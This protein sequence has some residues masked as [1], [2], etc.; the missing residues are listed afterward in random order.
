MRLLLLRRVKLMKLLSIDRSSM[1]VVLGATLRMGFKGK[2]SLLIGWCCP[3]CCWLLIVEDV[4]GNK[5]RVG[6]RLGFITFPADLKE[7]MHHPPF[8]SIPRSPR[9]I[10]AVVGSYRTAKRVGKTITSSDHNNAIIRLCPFAPLERVYH[11]MI[12]LVL[13]TARYQWF[14]YQHCHVL[15]GSP[16][17]TPA[18]ARST[19]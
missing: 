19:I 5:R 15:V 13:T 16:Q 6:I 2:T 7:A 3:Q 10:M 18:G 17:R 1:V 8:L 11:A 14:V 9:Q 4:L 12:I